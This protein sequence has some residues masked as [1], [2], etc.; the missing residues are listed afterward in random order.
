MQEELSQLLG[1]MLGSVGRGRAQV[2]HAGPLLRGNA[3]AS[4]PAAAGTSSTAGADAASASS[5]DAA[6]SS[7]SGLA[8]TASMPLGSLLSGSDE[9]AA[10]GLDWW[11]RETVLLGVLMT[12]LVLALP[13]M[14]WCIVHLEANYA[15][16]FPP[17]HMWALGFHL[18]GLILGLPSVYLAFRSARSPL[19]RLRAILPQGTSSLDHAPQ[20]LTQAI[21]AMALQPSQMLLSPNVG[22]S[23]ASLIAS[24]QGEGLPAGLVEADMFHDDTM[25]LWGPGV[26]E[27]STPLLPGAQSS[28]SSRRSVP[29]GAMPWQDLSELQL[30]LARLL[31]RPAAMQACSLA[32]SHMPQGELY[33]F[34]SRLQSAVGQ[35]GVGI[36]DFQSGMLEDGGH[37]PRQTRQ[38]AAALEA[39]SRA[40]GTAAAAMETSAASGEGTFAS[41][42]DSL[43]A[44]PEEVAGASNPASMVSMTTAEAVSSEASLS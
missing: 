37:L 35:I 11:S 14:L 42:S 44:V 20:V 3:G 13:I 31:G 32:P 26:E 16:G 40:L 6:A 29:N 25:P 15:V 8:A 5:S 1:A 12:F 43:R 23:S 41:N 18:L 36:C 24:L 7:S 39:A 21:A 10:S 34:L 9:F 22:M 19:Q 28:Q 27:V 38:L 17:W 2:L 33:A 4:S 30:Q